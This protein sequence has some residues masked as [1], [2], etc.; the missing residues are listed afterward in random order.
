MHINRS[1]VRISQVS[2]ISKEGSIPN[3]QGAV[4]FG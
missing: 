2:D 4:L 1:P 3:K